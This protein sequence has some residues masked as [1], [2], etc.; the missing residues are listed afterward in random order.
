MPSFFFKAVSPDGESV[1][2]YREAPDEQALVKS[3]QADGYLPIQVVP[4][5]STSL[6]WLTMRRFGRPRISQKDIGMFTRELATLLSAG[7]P[8]DR[9]LGILT[10]L[11]EDS[12]Q[13]NGL[14]RQVLEMVKGGAPLSAALESQSGVFSRF[15]LNMI[16]AGE[17]GGG[18]ED[19]L[20]RLSDYI[21]RSKEIRDTV[22]TAMIYP[23]ILVTM[24][25]LSLLGLLTFVVPQFT[26]MFASAGQ[27]LPLP[28][29]IVVAIADGLQSYWW[30]LLALIV[31]AV[32]YMRHQLADSARRYV[33]DRRFLRVPVVGDLIRKVEVANFS[34]TLGTLL[35]NGVSLL[36]AL[37]IV[38]ETLGNLV[39]AEAVG[40]AADRLKEGQDMAGPIIESGLFPKMA[41]QMIKL[42]EETGRLEEMLDRVAV[43]YDK[44]IKMAIQRMLALLE[45]ILIVGLG[46]LIGGIIAS[47][48]MAIMSVNDLAF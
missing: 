10:E 41:V 42:G 3:L 39:M 48:L 19:V 47:I 12:A 22:V 13:L 34:R 29:Q 4:V 28:T 18:L 31:V 46:L 38:K 27:E 16:R 21:E 33:W 24:A 37:S 32:S 45:P 36:V 40:V 23:A 35:R 5:G 14:T 44:E 2:E 15:Y 9:S 26:E 8:L 6:R 17:A 25:V 11:T 7:L 30:V 1:E 43:A 20:E